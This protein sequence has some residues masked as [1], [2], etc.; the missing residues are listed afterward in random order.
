MEDQVLNTKID[1]VLARLDAISTVIER[2]LPLIEM[3][4]MM[5]GGKAPMTSTGKIPGSIPMPPGVKL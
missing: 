4:E 2:M 3:A 1:E 5:A